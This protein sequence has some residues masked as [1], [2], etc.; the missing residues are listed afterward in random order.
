MSQQWSPSPYGRRMR[1]PVRLARRQPPRRSETRRRLLLLTALC[2]AWVGLLIW[3]LPQVGVFLSAQVSRL[4]HLADQGVTRI[5]TT[6]ASHLPGATVAGG[7]PHTT[8]Q[9]GLA[10]AGAPRQDTGVRATIETRVPQRVSKQTTNYFWVGAYLSDRSFVQAGYYVPGNDD[11]HAG[12][13]YCAFTADGQ[14]GPCTLGPLG[15]AG[16]NGAR[17]TYALEAEA[18]P[19]NA[20]G[21]T[22]W[23]VRM[24]GMTIGQFTWAAGDT[25]A[26]PPGIY[27]ESS[28]YAPHAATSQLGPVDFS[29]GIQVRPAG[30]TAYVAAPHALVQYNATNVCPPY[31]VA[32]DGSGGARLGSGLDCAAE[33]SMLW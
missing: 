19:G 12:W 21:A 5:V 17:H 22:I 1:D 23:H 4:A 10:A 27:A 2:A 3:P 33:D 8:W 29:G 6:G 7:G 32:A 13:F 16:G 20:K 30:Q 15:S 26:Y 18:P 28:G 14:K 25:G 11:A 9:V 24:D 31:G